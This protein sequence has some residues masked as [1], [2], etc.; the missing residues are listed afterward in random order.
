MDPEQP[1]RCGELRIFIHLQHSPPNDT[2]EA[3][4]EAESAPAIWLGYSDTHLFTSSLFPARDSAE[5]DED[6]IIGKPAYQAVWQSDERRDVTYSRDIIKPTGFIYGHV[7]TIGSD[8][9]TAY[10]TLDE[11]FV[12]S[13]QFS[14]GRW[15]TLF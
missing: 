13:E 2:E 11:E 14:R 5:R 6:S 3:Q 1:M 9:K 4:A 12:N 15:S 7:Q 8:N 10:L